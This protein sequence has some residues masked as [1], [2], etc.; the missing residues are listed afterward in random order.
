MSRRSKFADAAETWM[1]KHARG[2]TVS[3][4]SFGSG[5]HRQTRSCA[6]Q[7]RTARHREQ[8]A[9]GIYEKMIAS[10]SAT[11]KSVSAKAELPPTVRVR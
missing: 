6:L 2:E 4:M 3:T 7:V 8:P 9:C 5:Y 1:K 10:K 11:A